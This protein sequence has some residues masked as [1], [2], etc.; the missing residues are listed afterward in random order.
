METVKHCLVC[1]SA[2]FQ[3]FLSVTDHFL[4][5]EEFTLVKCN[6]CGFTFIKDRPE[7]SE[8]S[9][10]YKSTEYV[11][12]SST[13][14]GLVNWVYSKVRNYTLKKKL[15]LAGRFSK[16]KNILDYGCGTG[17]FLN[18]CQKK[19]WVVTG[20]EPDPDARKFATTDFQLPVFEINHLKSLPDKSF[21]V[22]T[23]WHVLEHVYEADL[24]L[25]EFMRLLKDDGVLILAV[26]NCNSFDAQHYKSNWAAYDV[27]RHIWH[28]SP[29]TLF[30]FAE[31]NGFQKVHF[32]GM[33]FDSYYISLLSEKY[34]HGKSSLF[35]GIWNGLLSNCKA[36]KNGNFSSFITILTKKN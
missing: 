15:K 31:K 34:L 26:P 10:Y 2:S 36:R 28:F 9:A 22:I 19:G 3:D 17:H 18:H 20:I 11:S 24:L 25:S 1:G 30:R 16:G 32:R 27:P 8:A 7:A 13:K 12:H 5:K 35:R 6:S 33:K 14:K 21:N 23:S 4:S 29:D